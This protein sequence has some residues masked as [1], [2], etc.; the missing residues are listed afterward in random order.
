MADPW[1][2]VG[3]A[4][5]EADQFVTARFN[6][7][8]SYAANAWAE[9]NS[10][11]SQLVV[12]ATHPAVNTNV[13]V[14]FNYT[15]DAITIASHGTKPATPIFDTAF[16]FTKPSLGTLKQ[17]PLFDILTSDLDTLKAGIITKLITVIEEGATGLDPVV[18]QAIFDRARSRQETDN[19]RL[20][21]EAENYFAARGFEMPT[22]ALSAKLQEINIEIT[23][24]NSNL[25]NDVMI[26]QAKLAQ[27]NFQFVVEKGASVVTSMVELGF[28][29]VI[30]YNKGTIEAFI[31]QLEAYKQEISTVL[32]KIDAQAKVYSAE[33]EVYKSCAQVDNADISA[34]VEIAKISLQEAELRANLELKQVDIELEAAMK[35]HQL[36]I[37]AYESGSKVTAQ[38][39]AS[40]LSAVNASASYGFSGGASINGGYTTTYDATKAVEQHQTQHIYQETKSV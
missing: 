27:S 16:N 6:E 1:T 37:A 33:A 25:N 4:A 29:S 32:T 26:E 35:L 8:Q 5:N 9:A 12:V 14:P 17:L 22:G 28:K 3:N 10:Y 15:G 40:A 18:E 23:R 19:L 21:T 2:Q 13:S 20:Y 36:Q 24:N 39:V 7:A 34:Q 30:D 31:A 38:V 11:L